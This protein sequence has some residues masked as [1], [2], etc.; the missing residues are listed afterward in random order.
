MDS[1]HILGLKSKLLLYRQKHQNWHCQVLKMYFKVVWA[2]EFPIC[3]YKLNLFVFLAPAHSHECKPR[4][5]NH[6]SLPMP[7]ATDSCDL[8]LVHSYAHKEWNDFLT[9]KKLRITHCLDPPTRHHVRGARERNCV[10]FLLALKIYFMAFRVAFLGYPGFADLDSYRI[11]K[12][13][14]ACFW[15]TAFGLRP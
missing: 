11:D 7:T 15:V 5:I 10:T 1:R 13:G 3:K 14:F 12:A 4:V 8:M 9:W 2:T 6:F